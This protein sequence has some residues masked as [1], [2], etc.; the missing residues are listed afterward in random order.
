M[1][2]SHHPLRVPPALLG[3][4]DGESLDALVDSSHRLRRFWPLLAT[5][6]QD[7]APAGSGFRVP[8]RARR[9]VASMPEYGS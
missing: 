9:V 2:P 6:P 8:S 4:A 3:D 7:S 5:G 1:L